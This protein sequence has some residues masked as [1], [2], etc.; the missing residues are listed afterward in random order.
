MKNI[1]VA[2]VARSG[3]STF[4]RKMQEDK[5]YN[6]IPLDYFA[7]SLKR[8]FPETQITSNV[9]I[10][11]MSSKNLGKL[12]SRVIEII[13]CQEENFIIDS[14]HVM[15]ED[16]VKYLDKEKW[17]IYYLGYPSLTAKEKLEIIRKYDS[18]ED[19]T[20]KRTDEELLEI[21][22]KLIDISKEMK[23]QCAELGVTFIDTG[24]N[25]NEAIQ[26]AEISEEIKFNSL[27]P[28]L[29]V[30]NVEKSIEFYTSIG[31]EIIY[32][33]KED[34]F[35][36]LQLEENQIMI[37]Q[38][39][40][41]W[42]TGALE[43]PFGRGINISMSVK[44]VEE[45]YDMLKKNNISFFVELKT[46]RYEANGVLYEDKEFLIQDPDGYLLRFNE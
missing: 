24:S 8:N 37:E 43:Y 32:E 13:N 4:A 35:C 25:V 44:N 21:L 10:D 9:V 23:R 15:P 2:G 38:I 40:D 5:K 34:K 30:S 28:E 39:N 22:D 26:K 19:W 14:A 42:N 17:D 18:K 1:F 16:I 27:I 6:H 46:S 11:K 12:L 3:K 20:F 41:N 36:F 31:F 33:R 45:Y 7:S 29:S